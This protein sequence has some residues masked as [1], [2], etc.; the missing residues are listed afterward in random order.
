MR[1]KRAAYAA[2]WTVVALSLTGCYGAGYL[3]GMLGR[4]IL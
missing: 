2:F 3:A 1:I 4:H